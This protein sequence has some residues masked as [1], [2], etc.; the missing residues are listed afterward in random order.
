MTARFGLRLALAAAIAASLFPAAGGAQKTAEFPPQLDAYFTKHAKLTPALRADLLKGQPVTAVLDGDQEHEVTIFG[1]AWIAAPLDRYLEKAL[2]IEEFERG[3][4]FRIT[5]LI[6]TPPRAEDFAVMDLPKDDVADLKS[7]RVGSCAIKIS[8]PSL[9][10]LRKEVDFS[11]QTVQQ[12]AERLVRT[13][14]LEYVTGYLEGGNAKLATYRDSDRPTFVA[15]E[16]KD[17][18]ERMP[19]LT[20]YLR[21]LKRYLLDFPQAKL[22]NSRS[23]LYWQEAQF[24]LEADDPDQ[25]RGLAAAADAR[26]R[27]LE[28]AVCKPLFLDG[29]RIARAVP[30]P[31]RG[32]GFWFVS[33]NRSRSDGLTGFTGSVIRGRVRGEAEKG[34]LAALRRTK[35]KLETSRNAGRC[36]GAAGDRPFPA[37]ALPSRTVDRLLQQRETA[38]LLSAKLEMIAS[39]LWL[40]RMPVC[41]SND[42]PPTSAVEPLHTTAPLIEHSALSPLTVNATSCVTSASWPAALATFSWTVRRTTWLGL[43]AVN[44][45]TV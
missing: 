16:F 34:M 18:I 42:A 29:A 10:R 8:E 3:D 26:G 36:S 41:P 39:E 20:E 5:K 37:S 15:N 35:A 9:A 30:H 14:A 38:Y 11:K 7:C 40:T 25:S 19:A 45:R 31:A 22:P 13:L 43:P 6:S 12:D 44:C 28:D 24:G 17:M 33:V 21:D 1:A 4:N 27:R 2:D 32:N 23:F